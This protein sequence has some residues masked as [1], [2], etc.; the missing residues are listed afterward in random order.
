MKQT[1]LHTFSLCLALISLLSVGNALALECG[2][3]NFPKCS[4]ALRQPAQF[5]GG[6][7]PPA[8]FGGFGGGAGCQDK[9][10]HTP[11]VLVHGNGD[12]AI[13]WDS[14]APA[15]T[16]KP[17]RPSVFEELKA[18]GYND[19]EVFGVTYLDPAK[20]EQEF[21]HTASN[22]HQPS[23]YEV[24]WRFIES[25]KAYTG[26]PKV[27]IVGHSLGVSMSL[28]AL[29]YH[30]DAEFGKNDNAWASVRRFVN[31]AGGL[32]G[33]NACAGASDFVAD[34]CQAEQSGPPGAFYEFGFRPEYALLFGGGGK[35][36]RWTSE[37]GEHSMRQA[38]QRHPSVA[39]YTINAGEQDDIHCPKFL[40]SV[41]T[42]IN[43]T[44]GPLFA[45]ASNVRAQLNIGVDPTSKPPP[46][47]KDVDQSFKSL[48]PRD[49]GGIGHFGARNYAGPIITQMLSTDCKGTACKGNYVGKVQV[50][51]P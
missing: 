24:I 35:K 41:L 44:S 6:F 25:V 14:P 46:W 48:V 20:Q 26:S 30:S 4:N 1:D 36:N 11:V 17:Q 49:M 45:P 29:D 12:S 13:G 34:T 8:P 3:F 37:Q 32:R 7:T 16:G 22:F 28:A 9:I 18:R 19:C 39:F 5:A 47:V 38:P 40:D 50:A 27:D 15:R 10:T 51:K 43:C 2:G 42:P 23:K 31:I 21:D 33:L